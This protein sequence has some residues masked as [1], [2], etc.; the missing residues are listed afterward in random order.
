[1]VGCGLLRDEIQ[2][3]TFS[4]ASERLR[5]GDVGT[6]SELIIKAQ[7]QTPVVDSVFYQKCL[8]TDIA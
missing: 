1:M 4:K 5:R 3:N 7:N 8:R 6:E 2:R